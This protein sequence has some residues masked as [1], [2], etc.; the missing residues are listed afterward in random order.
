MALL[1]A[2]CF[3]LFFGVQEKII[4]IT[5][6]WHFLSE[7]VHEMSAPFTAGNRARTNP[8]PTNT[9]LVRPHLPQETPG[10]QMTTLPFSRSCSHSLLHFQLTRQLSR[11]CCRLTPFPLANVQRWQPGCGTLREWETDHPGGW[12]GMRQSPEPRWSV[13]TPAV[14]PCN[15]QPPTPAPH[16]ALRGDT[17]KSPVPPGGQAWHRTA[18]APWPHAPVS[19]SSMKCHKGREIPQ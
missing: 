11:C 1:N 14:Q 18:R 16:Q 12:R 6:R 19:S 13:A 4:I 8:D 10:S 2:C 17:E 15:G 5:A 9:I 3:S 7:L